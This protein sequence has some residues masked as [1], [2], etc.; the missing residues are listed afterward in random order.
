MRMTV[1]R[2]THVAPFVENVRGDIAVWAE[3][4]NEQG[5]I[6]LSHAAAVSTAIA[7]LR[8]VGQIAGASAP[9]LPVQDIAFTPRLCAD[10]ETVIK[11]DLTIEG[12]TLPA[13][14]SLTK[15]AEI[16]AL[17]STLSRGIDN[18]SIQAV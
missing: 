12:V 9:V 8:T 10:G 5:G 14:I 11:L 13:E 17:T 4:D 18:G 15:L 1:V 3:I 16:A 2:C 7:I 6:I